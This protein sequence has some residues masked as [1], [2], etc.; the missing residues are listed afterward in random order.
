[1]NTTSIKKKGISI[2]KYLT[3]FVTLIILILGIAVYSIVIH[4]V[5]FTIKESHKQHIDREIKY[6]KEAILSYIDIRRMEILDLALNPIVIQAV[7]DPDL[8][9]GFIEEQMDSWRIFQ[10][11]EKI[12]LLDINGH[13]IYTTKCLSKVRPDWEYDSLPLIKK[14]IKK[15]IISYT[16]YFSSNNS[17]FWRIAAPVKVNNKAKGILIL[18]IPIKEL[19]T[20]NQINSRMKNIKLELFNKKTLIAS[21]GD[22]QSDWCKTIKINELGLSLKLIYNTHKSDL[23]RQSLRFRIFMTM[24]F[25]ILL[26]VLVILHFGNRYIVRPIQSLIKL[27]SQLASGNSIDIPN[28]VQSVSEMSELKEHFISMSQTIK[29]REQSLIQSKTRLSSVLSN[30]PVL[31]MEIS[32]NRKIEYINRIFSENP[33]EEIIGSDLSYYV[34]PEVRKPLQSTIDQVLLTKTPAI[35]ELALYFPNSEVI[36]CEC[37]IGTSFKTVSDSLIVVATDITERRSAQLA[38]I[39]KSEFLA[40]MSHEIRTPLNGVIGFTEL[41]SKTELSEQQ[42]QYI[43]NIGFS[44]HSLMNQLNDILD[45]SKIEAGKMD[46]NEI[47]TD[48]IELIEQTTEIVKYDALKKGIKLLL[49]I[50]PNM[51]RFAVVDPV[52]LKQILINLLN[53]AVKF[54]EKGEVGISIVYT[55]EEE[56]PNSG[57]FTFAIRD[58]GIGISKENQQKLFKAFSQADSSITRKFG[59][60]GLG[61]AIS[62]M[63]AVKMGGKI[64]IESELEKGSKFS[65]TITTPVEYLEKDITDTKSESLEIPIGINK[66]EYNILIAEDVEI[67]MIL[68]KTLIKQVIPSGIIIES[69]NGEDAVEK[70]KDHVLDIIF[71]DI[72]MPKMDGYTA[73]TEIRK[74][75][76]NTEKHCPI[77]ALTASAVKGEEEKCINS[78]MDSYLSKPIIPAVLIKIIKKF[79]KQ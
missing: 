59:G 38:N 37:H 49:E 61:L 69:S 17:F 6:D 22:I 11:K 19:F 21:F 68:L 66:K 74:L 18:E 50:P 43:K 24:I 67:N 62:N 47:R 64:I 13:I 28:I 23:V 72:Q 12:T 15:E 31:I 79:L 10:K 52:R 73:A 65:F 44:A 30:S 27:T 34:I 46:L 40:N 41:L 58:T 76:K 56:I 45:F 39:A 51:A 75:E 3:F 2:S 20:K 4:Q 57:S 54:T 77:I 14:L 25:L 36:L 1:M 32:R 53:N 60:T 63:L 42:Q 16:G 70:F 26:T 8:H 33:V 35:L 5:D 55:P 71:M 29:L 78:G 48:I 7:K 9:H